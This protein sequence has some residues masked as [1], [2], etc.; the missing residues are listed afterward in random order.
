MKISDIQAEAHRTAKAKG[1][2][3]DPP[4]FGTAIALMHSELS[5]AL[6]AHRKNHTAGIAEEFADLVIRV[7][8][9]CEYMGI[10]LESAVA[11]KMAFNRAR[12]WKHGKEY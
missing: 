12:P 8:D 6:E 4:H 10:D 1:F 7:A 5:E 9:T 2:Y 11:L 3:D